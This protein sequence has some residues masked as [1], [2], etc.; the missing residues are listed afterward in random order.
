MCAVIVYVRVHAYHACELFDFKH[1][2]RRND[3]NNNN[4]VS[5]DNSSEAGDGEDMTDP[6]S[7]VLHAC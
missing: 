7:Y 4:S 5:E 6:L 2:N 1:S 3:N